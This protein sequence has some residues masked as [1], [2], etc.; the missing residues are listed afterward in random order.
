MSTTSTLSNSVRG[1]YVNEYIKGA[2]RRRVYDYFC[3]PISTDPE[4]LQK[5]S[6]ITVPFI[7]R[8]NPGTTA[9]SE[10]V[11]V[12]PQTL[13]DATSSLSPTSRG[14]AIQDSEKL[15]LDAYTD[16]AARRYEIV[17]ENM[18][19]S[20]E[21]VLIETALA[22]S[23]VQRGA[24]RASL[25]AGT[26]SQYLTHAQLREM[27]AK[28]LRMK[29]PMFEEGGAGTW[30]AACG[31]ENVYDL[32]TQEPILSV[33]KYQNMTV[34]LG[35]D[36]VGVVGRFRIMNSPWT[37]IFGAA[38]ADNASAGA[39][40]LASAAT[41]LSKTIEVASASNLSAGSW[42]TI[43]TEE[44]ASTF[45]PSNERVQYVSE[46]GTTITIVGSG[47]NGGLRYDHAS[48]VAV[49]NADSV[50]PVLCGGPNSIAK[51]YASDLGN[52]EYGQV[53]GPNM[54]GLLDQFVSLGWKWY[55]GFARISE[56]WLGRIEVTS[57][58]D[59]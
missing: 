29:T 5:Q 11:D 24:A 18:M 53:V 50:Y 22:G 6:S 8:M 37:K 38:G 41:R 56:G 49:R 3:Y 23:I 46:S 44:T 1:R 35:I 40:T 39:T 13:T 58:F 21:A 16:Y 36:E 28:L 55:G 43:G 59:A 51:A 32:E 25:D 42:L 47:D 7:S 33:A 45:Y 52:G 4:I 27:E 2:M 19:E 34:I 9:V 17:G 30:A 26:S 48:G 54:Q 15:L 57:A 31:P 20:V 14:E 10:T 12:T